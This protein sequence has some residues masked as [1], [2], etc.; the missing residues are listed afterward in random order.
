M[1]SLIDIITATFIG[2]IIILMIIGINFYIQTS[3]SEINYSSIAQRNIQEISNLLAYDF[4]K[5]GYRVTGSKIRYADSTNITFL[6]DINNDGII[7]S[8][9]YVLGSKNELLNT[10]NPE[11]KILYRALN[12]EQLKGSNLG[13]VSFKLTYYDSTTSKVNY[14]LLT[15]QTYRDKIKAIEYYIRVESLAPIEGY[16]LGAEIKKVIRPKNL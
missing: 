9:R 13:V 7:D 6:P 4:S 16:Y 11:D 5:I 2:G 14:N 12:N 1:A 10:P 15:Q 8:V 3:A